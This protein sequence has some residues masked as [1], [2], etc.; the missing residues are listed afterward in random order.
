M[1]RRKFLSVGSASVASLMLPDLVARAVP[2]APPVIQ[3]GGGSPVTT[4][5]ASSVGASF[6]ITSAVGGAL[7]PFTVG[8]PFKQ[9]DIPSG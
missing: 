8:Q 1:K 9:G 4:S 2:C 6:L 7:L 5:C 3:V